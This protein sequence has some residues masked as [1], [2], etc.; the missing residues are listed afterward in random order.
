M[1][2]TSNLDKYFIFQELLEF[3]FPL[4]FLSEKTDVYY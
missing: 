3:F 4:F 1:I 2:F